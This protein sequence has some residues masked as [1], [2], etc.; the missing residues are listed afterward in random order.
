MKV[1]FRVDAGIAMG[2]GH[3]S[4]CLTI[5]NALILSGISKCF[6]ILKSHQG[7]F[8][9]TIQSYGFEFEIL[10]LEFQPDYNTEDYSQWV[11]GSI[12]ND[13]RL[14]LSV[15]KEKGFTDKDWLIVDHY[16]LDYKFEK[17]IAKSGI[18]IGVIDDLVNRQHSCKFL[19][20]Q[21]CGRQDIEYKK[22][23]SSDTYLMTGQSF[24]MLRP[25]FLKL[26]K[27]SLL[28]RSKF[29]D[30]KCIFINFGSTDPTNVTANIISTLSK[31][32]L[33]SE[34]SIVVA[35][36]GNTPHLCEIQKCISIFPG[37][38]NLI[39][40]AI[41]MSELMYQADLA[42]G[43]AGATTWERCALGLPTIIIKTAEN[44][45]TVIER[46]IEFDVAVLHDL[47][48][49]NQPVELLKHLS[50]IQENYLYMSKQCSVLVQ[51]DGV[52][53]VVD[54]ILRCKTK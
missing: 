31:V 43:A 24:C 50:Y 3:L 42:I 15:L 49:E 17:L 40:D 11:G 48:T 47:D 54:R 52:N 34:V 6:F 25:E 35:V 44:Q 53:K 13:G 21:T 33:N 7:N 12:L 38:I 30:I 19:I 10:P 23:V 46:I 36:G 45:S 29:N 14:S 39:V 22:L 8:A 26:R 41:N 51:G 5:A 16:G 18:N 28:K 20:D 1:A 2:G 9:S 32:K 27:A 37:K 4:R